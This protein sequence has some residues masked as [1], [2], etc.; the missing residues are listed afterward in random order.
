MATQGATPYYNNTIRV[1][2]NTITPKYQGGIAWTGGNA[3]GIDVYVYTIIKTAS[4][5]FTVLASQTKFT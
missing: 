4:A 5:T 1:D 2:G 3:S